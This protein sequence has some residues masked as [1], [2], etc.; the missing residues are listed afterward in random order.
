MEPGF[1]RFRNSMNF[2]V[3]NDKMDLSCVVTGCNDPFNACVSR[4]QAILFCCYARGHTVESLKNENL[5]LRRG[6]HQ[7]ILAVAECL[8]AMAIT[9]GIVPA[10]SRQ[11]SSLLTLPNTKD[12]PLSGCWR[13]LPME[14]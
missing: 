1:L 10:S 4:N 6:A 5:F 9:T 11:A 12:R 14:C 3:E 13:R 2:Q 8:I 7:H